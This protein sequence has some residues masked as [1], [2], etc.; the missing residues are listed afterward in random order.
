MKTSKNLFKHLIIA[1]LSVVFFS[2]PMAI[3][4]TAAQDGDAVDEINRRA[5]ALHLQNLRWGRSTSWIGGNLGTGNFGSNPA[6]GQQL[7]SW[8]LTDMYDDTLTFDL[9]DIERPVVM[10]LWASWCEPCR[11]E[12]PLL[13]EYAIDDSLNYDLW[14]VNTGDTT[15]AAG[16]RFLRDQS[17]ELTTMYDP[18][19]RFAN[20]LGLRAYPTTLLIDTDGTV[21][22]AHAGIV[23]ETAMDFFNA[24][25]ASPRDGGIDTSSLEFDLLD[26]LQPIDAETA[27]PLSYNQQS[28]G[29]ITDEDWRDDYRF[30]GT[31]GEEITINVTYVSDELDT[32]IALISPDGELVDPDLNR[33]EVDVTG[34]SIGVTLPQDG[35]YVL[36][37]ARF[38]EDE[39]FGVGGYNI[40]INTAEAVSQPG[41]GN[42]LVLQS[43]V[44]STG[45]LTYERKQEA[46]TLDVAVGQTVTFE[47]T[48][49]LPEEEVSLQA[50]LGGTRLV[51]YTKTVDGQL[52]V[53]ATVEEAG[54]YSVYVARSNSSRAGP[55]TYTLSVTVEGDA[56]ESPAA[57]GDQNTTLVYG[58]TVSNSIDD[59][60]FEHT[61]YFTGA[62]GDVI[63]IDMVL[64]AGDL[65]ANLLLLNAAGDVIANNDDIDFTTSNARIADFELHADG[66]YAITATRYEGEAGITSGTFELT[67]QGMGDDTTAPPSTDTDNNDS[68]A[69]GYG[70]TVTGTIDGDNVRQAF[71]FEGTAG[72]TI[73]VDIVG[74]GALDTYLILLGPDG[75]VLVENDDV[76]V[77]TTNA[78]LRDFV[79]LADGTHTIVV[80]R[81]Q[82][83]N[84]LSVGDFTLTLTLVDSTDV[85]PPTTDTV[86]D[87]TYGDSASGVINDETVELRYTFNGADGDVVSIGVAGT[88]GG[89]D[90][91]VE[92]IGPD[93][94]VVAE[95]DDIDILTTDSAIVDFILPADG[96]YTIVVSR[97]N[98][99]AGRSSGEFS[100]SLT[101]SDGS[102]SS[103]PDQAEVIAI[104]FNTPVSG[105]ITNRIIERTYTFEGQAGDVVSISVI[106][107]GFDGVDAN[108]TLFGPEGEFLVTN[109]DRDLFGGDLNPLISNFEL[110]TTGT[111]TVVVGR[112]LGEDG[113]STG[114]FTLTLSAGDPDAI[115]DTAIVYGDIVTGTINSSNFQV[116]YIFEG[117]SGDVVSIRINATSGNLD[118][119][120]LLSDPRGEFLAF[121][122][123]FD[124]LNSAIIDVVLPQDGSYTI[125]AGRYQGAN[126]STSGDY[127]LE[128]TADGIDV[129]IDEPDATPEAPTTTDATG[130]D[131]VVYTD[132]ISDANFERTYTFEG[133]SGDVVTIEMIAD[134]GT[135]DSLLILVGPSGNE[136]ARNDD[137]SLTST[138]ALLPDLTLSETGTYTIIA[139][140]YQGENGLSAGNF[141]LTLSI[142]SAN[143]VVDAGSDT[144]IDPPAE[145]VPGVEGGISATVMAVGDTVS[146]T[147][148]GANLEDRYVFNGTAGQ[149][150]TI[151]MTTIS[152]SLDPYVSLL[153]EQGTEIAFNDDDIKSVGNDA[154]ILGFK[155]PADGTYTI[156]ATRYGVFYGITIGDYELTLV[157]Q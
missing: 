88:A 15:L 10:N 53:E 90:T 148:D 102:G 30:E 73:S 52:T 115:V 129:V 100:L 56:P 75:D 31:A 94:E 22:A 96:T 51:S 33:S 84:G 133:S 126:G 2:T 20:Q 132:E 99:E 149:V 18:N 42:A 107:E 37:V 98:G 66:E 6:V 140:R 109:D 142:I 71:N 151:T 4:P 138:D 106:A 155:L 127:E 78:G 119:T 128:L 82:Q 92:L 110:P 9:E 69:F 111:Y 67:L 65:D 150:I 23:T 3:Q 47:L 131:A 143:P 27:T 77:T 91:R 157:Q 11:F 116:A 60:T 43:G 61:Y 8:T 62:A 144:G 35:T 121:N 46:Y 49:D 50:R 38:L 137:Q 57:G 39:G 97:F 105:S 59:E 87:L 136:V 83:E 24:L 101:L 113:T 55:I 146:G 145:P 85:S 139:T 93:G 44:S 28:A 153:D 32:Y 1:L 80:T 13:T 134:S 25:A 152:G 70:S 45:I 74:S 21:I 130:A 34:L 81:F 36:I 120:L 156:V 5:E 68:S 63:T 76:E 29:I 89:L 114:D 17:P 117:Q 64:V 123:D 19:D 108:L 154:V 58:D 104:A 103:T 135:L 16:Q 40:I 12:F 86:V 7:T 141:T 124:G 48:H 72:D 41:A 95:N 112:Y 118:T 122:D 54:T 125:T 26:A 79:L 147:I 14:F